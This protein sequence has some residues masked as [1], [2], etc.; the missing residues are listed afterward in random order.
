M[1]WPW[2]DHGLGMARPCFTKRAICIENTK[3]TS[4]LWD[5]PIPVE[6]A[7]AVTGEWI[8]HSDGLGWYNTD[9]LPRTNSIVYSYFSTKTGKYSWINTSCSENLSSIL[10]KPNNRVS[11]SWLGPQ[12]GRRRGLSLAVKE[13][14]C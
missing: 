6:R 10:Y 13:R 12:P 2:P 14:F 9:I 3:N 11:G 1:A 8:Q 5:I 7:D 4:Y